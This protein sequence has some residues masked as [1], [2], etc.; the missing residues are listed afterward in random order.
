MT[1]TPGPLGLRFARAPL[2]L[3][4]VGVASTLAGCH[5]HDYGDRAVAVTTRLDCPSEQGELHRTD[6]ASDGRSCRYAGRDGQEVTL[7]YLALDGRSPQEALQATEAALRADV[8]AAAA[9]EPGSLRS[10]AGD[11]VD[12]PGHADR[13]DDDKDD[14][15]RDTGG[16]ARD[17]PSVPGAP[18]PPRPPAPPQ[19]DG[20]WSAS[21]HRDDPGRDESGDRVHINLPFLHVDADGSG[22]AHVRTFGVDVQAD[23]DGAAV[24]TP[25]GGAIDAHHGGAEMRFGS[26]GRRRADLV[27]ILASDHAGPQ[28]FRSGAYVARGPSDG[29]LVLA[30]SR[31][32]EGSGRSREGDLHDVKRLVNANVRGF[33]GVD[34]DID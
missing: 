3:A 18:T 16:S 15:D 33:R 10:A 29:P 25:G 30:V 6:A 24:H 14:D 21:S 26:V 17:A 34:F 13:D 31:S 20:A 32:R 8:P 19:V 27:Y 5:R 22:R 9:A 7:A 28:G 1:A 12:K 4:A 11:E 2:L 23:G